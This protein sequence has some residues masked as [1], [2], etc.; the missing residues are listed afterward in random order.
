MFDFNNFLRQITEMDV[1][2]IHLRVNEVPVVRKIQ[3]GTG[4]VANNGTSASITL[5]GFTNINKMIV[6]LNGG[7]SV[8]ASEYDSSYG[9]TRLPFVG[10]LSLSSLTVN[11]DNPVTRK[12][13][14]SF[15][16]QVIEFW[17]QR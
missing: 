14:C 17:A 12:T 4:S 3:R 10:S 2:D 5:S 8:N 13:A 6:L 15:S 9:I 1:S 7:T 11:S 16:Y